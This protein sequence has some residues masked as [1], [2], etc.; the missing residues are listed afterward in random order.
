MAMIQLGAYTPS[1]QTDPNALV[2]AS[3]FSIKQRAKLMNSPFSLSFTGEILE[4]GAYHSV[5]VKDIS[6]FERYI[7]QLHP[8]YHD[9][10]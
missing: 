10:G 8:Y 6:S 7:A 3:T 4:M 1:A 2:V 5:R 9:L